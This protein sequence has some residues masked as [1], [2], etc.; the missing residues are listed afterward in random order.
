VIRILIADDHEVV[1]YGLRK[2]FERQPGWEV[3]AETS[4][5]KD[6]ISKAL[7]TMPDVAIL[8]YAMPLINGAEATRQI[9]AQLPNTEVLIFT[10]YDDGK[11]IQECLRAGARSYVLKDDTENQLISAVE[12]LAMHKPFFTGNV[13]E[14]LLRSLLEPPRVAPQ[15]PSRHRLPAEAGKTE[16]SVLQ[17]VVEGHNEQHIAERL[18]MNLKLVKALMNAIRNR[19]IER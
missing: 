7:E 9:H 18:N 11:F 19:T 4:N 15:S 3:V 10:A 2:T 1:R 8:D 17:L 6:A 14:I 16:C 12:F 5:G 13:A